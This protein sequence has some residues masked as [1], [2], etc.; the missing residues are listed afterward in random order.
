MGAERITCLVLVGF[1]AL[2]FAVPAEAKAAA[3]KPGNP[4]VP[5]GVRPIRISRASRRDAIAR[6]RKSLATPAGMPGTTLAEKGLK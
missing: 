6:P 5:P 4:P 2:G 3:P 1:S